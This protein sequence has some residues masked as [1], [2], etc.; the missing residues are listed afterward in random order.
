MNTQYNLSA[1]LLPRF[2][3]TDDEINNEWANIYQIRKEE[4]DPD[5]FQTRRQSFRNR[6]KF[7]FIDFNHFVREHFKQQ[8]QAYYARLRTNYRQCNYNTSIVL[9]NDGSWL[10]AKTNFGFNESQ[11]LAFRA[12]LTKEFVIIQGPPGNLFYNILLYFI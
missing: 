4:T 7:R 6:S 5:N 3:V 9:L 11:L 8:K 10:S 2:K 12:A 1:I